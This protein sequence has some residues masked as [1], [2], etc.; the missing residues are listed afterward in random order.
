MN[1]EELSDFDK[2]RIK[3]SGP[4]P[5]PHDYYLTRFVEEPG[6]GVKAEGT[7]CSN[8]QRMMSER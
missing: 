2:F 7:L 4:H 5:G 6:I 3:V 8:Y 1:S